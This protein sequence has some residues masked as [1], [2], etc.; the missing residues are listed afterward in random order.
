MNK[1]VIKGSRLIYYQE[2]ADNPDFWAKYWT[3]EDFLILPKIAAEGMRHVDFWP[4]LIKY[5]S[6]DEEILEGG[7]AP[8]HTIVALKSQGYKIRGVDFSKE[9]ISQIKKVYSDAPVEFGNILS[10]N[11]PDKF[12]GAYIL[13]GVTEHFIEGPEKSLLE[14]FRVLRRGGRLLVSVPFF[15]PIR[16]I[17]AFLGLIPKL[18][19]GFDIK[20]F[21]QYAFKPSEF[22]KIL[23]RTGFK[24]VKI[25]YY[26]TMKGI[27]DE[28][29]LFKKL[30][31][32]KKIPYRVLRF[33]RSNNFIKTMTSHMV[34]FVAERSG[35]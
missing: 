32:Q 8:G 20:N 1:R 29:P 16:N 21:Y 6:K 24:V 25:H 31:E 35:P 9:A 18:T 19:G 10:L 5:L 27:K 33:L 23:E 17:K 28:F 14:A 15:N 13:L 7:C 11:Y 30:L 3:N 22:V 2:R 26:S 34:L 4:L 12:F